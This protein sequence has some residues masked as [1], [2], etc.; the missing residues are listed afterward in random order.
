MHGTVRT[1]LVVSFGLLFGLDC[2][3]AYAANA[4]NTVTISWSVTSEP[5]QATNAKQ[6]AKQ[7]SL[8]N[9]IAAIKAISNASNHVM[10]LFTKKLR[11]MGM[12]ADGAGYFALKNH[13][14]RFIDA[15]RQ[16]QKGIDQRMLDLI[17]KYGLPVAEKVGDDG[18]M[19]SA[20]VMANTLDP[21]GAAKFAELWKSGCAKGVLPCAAYAMIE[22]NA[23]LMRAG[24][25]RFGTSSGVP[26]AK[27]SNLKEVNDERAK[28]GLS[29]L[30]Q[31]CMDSITKPQS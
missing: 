15:L 22:D 27:G 31:T 23:L 25:Q 11:T 12:N 28:I 1:I 10:V 26:F 3:V 13:D 14:P 18:M 9:Y 6:L 7:G 16:K 19:S 21:A 30:S 20:M 4:C 24:I 17:A 8:P 5:G 29:P 2:S